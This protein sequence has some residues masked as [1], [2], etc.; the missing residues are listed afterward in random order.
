MSPRDWQ[1]L[2]AVAL[3]AAALIGLL[4]WAIA[5]VT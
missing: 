5:S 3:V 1:P 2:V 4:V